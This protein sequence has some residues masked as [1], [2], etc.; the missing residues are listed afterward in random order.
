MLCKSVS[1][2]FITD[3]LRPFLIFSLII[4]IFLLIILG[5]VVM[6]LVVVHY[7]FNTLQH[8]SASNNVSADA[9]L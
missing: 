8:L 3:T 9:V 1:I 7:T 4:F 5:Q 6:P 2:H